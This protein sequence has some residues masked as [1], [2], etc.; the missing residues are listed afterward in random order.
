M[1]TDAHVAVITPEAA[2][3]AW[4]MWE[5]AASWARGKPVIPVFVDVA[6]EEVPGPLRLVAQGVALADVGE[7]VAALLGAVGGK[8]DEPL[9]DEELLTLQSE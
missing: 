7:A 9:S 3:S 4:V 6:P 5:A 1:A 2:K 8:A